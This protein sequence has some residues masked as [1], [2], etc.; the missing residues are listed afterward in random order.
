[1]SDSGFSIVDTNLMRYCH[2]SHCADCYDRHI[3]DTEEIIEV[4]SNPQNYAEEKRRL[5]ELVLAR[6]RAK[7]EAERTRIA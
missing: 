4:L 5:I 3:A 7:E 1:M 6:R 2:T